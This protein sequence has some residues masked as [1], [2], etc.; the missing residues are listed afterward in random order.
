MSEDY[1]KM[2][3]KYTYKKLEE[4]GEKV[5]D[6]CKNEFGSSKHYNDYPYVVFEFD[7]EGICGEFFPHNNQIIICTPALDS[8][9]EF[10]ET[11]IHEYIHYMQSKTWFTR[12]S[13]PPYRK[14]ELTAEE[15]VDYLLRGD[16]THPYEIEADKV[17]KRNWKK[18]KNEALK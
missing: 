18:C 11:I 15:F 2:K 1:S 12:Y 8:I 9:E 7:E 10:I 5:I 14:N 3:K 16:P 13:N 17:A 4:I 6:W